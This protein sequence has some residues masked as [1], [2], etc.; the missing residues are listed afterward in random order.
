MSGVLLVV[1]MGCGSAARGKACT[2]DGDCQEW[3]ATCVAWLT[4]SG[5]G[6]RTCEVDCAEDTGSCPDGEQCITRPG[7]PPQTCQ[8]LD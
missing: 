8:T 3:A 6:R 4:T 1:L 5:E 2:R 7:A